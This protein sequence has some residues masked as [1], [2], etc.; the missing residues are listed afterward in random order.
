MEHFLPKYIEMFAETRIHRG[1]R[2]TEIRCTGLP[3][4]E[5]IV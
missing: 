1:L 5:F 2:F 3:K 4:Q